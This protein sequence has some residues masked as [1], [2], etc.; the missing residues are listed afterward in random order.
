MVPNKEV[1]LRETYLIHP[2]I[3]YKL[4]STYSPDLWMNTH[5]VLSTESKR[6]H[7]QVCVSAKGVCMLH[8][9]T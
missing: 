5:A 7:I 4:C 8:N 6:M 9:L 1:F 3:L 2:L